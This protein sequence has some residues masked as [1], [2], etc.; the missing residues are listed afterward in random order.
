MSDQ[1]DLQIVAEVLKNSQEILVAIGK[2]PSLDQVAAGLGLFLCFKKLGKSVSITCPSL[3]VVEFSHLVGLDKI[4]TTVGNKN[5]VVS[6][7]YVQDSIEKVSYN[8]EG[9]KFNLV[10]QPKKGGKPLDSHNVSYS[11]AGMEADMVF[12]IGAE[13]FDDLGEIYTKNQTAFTSAYTVSINK[14]LQNH[15]AQT[16]IVDA[17]SS[18]LSEI[19]AWFLEQMGN[20]AS[21]DSASNLLAGIDQATNRFSAPDI[22]AGAFIAAGKLMQNG[23]QR[24][25]Q[26]ARPQNPNLPLPLVR[27]MTVSQSQD[28]APQTPPKEWLE[29]KI[30]QG[31]SKI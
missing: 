25:V 27:P 4:T 5:L 8:V 22:K 23:A 30:F 6:F 20:T 17:A 26:I 3:M 24:D 21:G 12:I 16:N 29:P 19:A 9:N 11:Y 13:S 18:S 14:I 7:D 15:F 31:S 10:V 1:I 28:L 2:E